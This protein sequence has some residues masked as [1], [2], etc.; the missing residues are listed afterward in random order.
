VFVNA[1]ANACVARAPVAVL[2]VTSWAEKA[3]GG[4]PAAVNLGVAGTSLLATS[5]GCHRARD[6]MTAKVGATLAGDVEGVAIPLDEEMAAGCCHE[7]PGEAEALARASAR[8]A[9]A[10][11]HC[12]QSA[13]LSS[14]G[15]P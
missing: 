14:S 15:G 7:T 11:G 13:A 2:I 9:P 10:A 4:G 12:Q 3:A 6:V 8:M 5:V 1:T